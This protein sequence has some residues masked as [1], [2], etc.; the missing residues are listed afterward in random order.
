MVLASCEAL[1]LGAASFNGVASTI[2]TKYH[3][4]LK[5]KGGL[6]LQASS[7]SVCVFSVERPAVL[8]SC[9]VFLGS[10]MVLLCS[11]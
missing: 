4:I 10:L 6:P 8:Q 3:K 9:M 11:S 1:R 2:V 7:R 5:G